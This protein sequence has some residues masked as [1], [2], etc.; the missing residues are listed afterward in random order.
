MPTNEELKDISRR[1]FMKQA[2]M[3]GAGLIIATDL[4]APELG[5]S[6]PESTNSTMMGVPVEAK[7]RVRLG[8]IGVGGRGTSLL[9]DLLAVENVEIKA[10][11]DLVPEKVARAQKAVKDAGPPDPAALS[12][13]EKDFE[14]C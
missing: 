1:S 9:Q 10:I 2:A 11:C 3:G 6:A 5:A 14:N 7:E 8:I 12:K 13:G 4:L